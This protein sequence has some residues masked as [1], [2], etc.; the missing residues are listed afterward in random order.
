MKDASFG[1]RQ[2]GEADTS[3]RLRSAFAQMAADQRLGLERDP[4]NPTWFRA[5]PS[6]PGSRA[7]ARRA[8]FTAN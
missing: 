7:G 4:D 3:T 1:D 5:G 6:L 8:R 2:M